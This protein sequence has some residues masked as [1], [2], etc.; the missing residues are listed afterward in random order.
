MIEA[1]LLLAGRAIAVFPLAAGTKIPVAGSHGCR[2]ATDDIDVIR[3]RWTK[4]PTANIGIATGRESGMWALDVDPQH[5]GDESLAE[6]EHKHGSL[7]LTIEVST[8]SGGRHLYWR[9]QTSGPDIRNSTSRIGPGLDVRGEGGSITAPPSVLADGR[10]YCWVK[11]GA[12]AFADASAWLVEAALPPPPPPRRHPKPLTGDVTA[13]VA[14][15]ASSEL[16]E[17][18]SAGE[19]TRNQTLNRVTFNL[20][21]LVKAGV[22]P[23]DW[24]RAQLEERAAEIGLSI[25][26]ARRTINSAFKAAIPRSMP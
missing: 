9:W 4:N 22:L 25:F 1:A 11:N 17:L 16:H 2:D 23:E 13:Y 19:G 7:P 5:G 18:G 12:R 6:L 8:P 20:A 14:Q 24:T 15:A 21:S 26:E 10:R 3:S